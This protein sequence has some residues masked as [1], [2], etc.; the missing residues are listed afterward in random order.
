MIFDWQ[1]LSACKNGKTCSLIQ[2]TALSSILSYV[3]YLLKF[4]SNRQ[5]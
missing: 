5:K 3:I 2:L 4:R 1:G